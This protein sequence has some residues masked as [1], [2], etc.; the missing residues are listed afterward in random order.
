MRPLLEEELLQSCET[1]IKC[2]DDDQLVVR[3]DKVFRFDHVFSPDASQVSNRLHQLL[4]HCYLYSHTT[5]A[6]D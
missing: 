5:C 4:T 2:V 6:T 1:T 3:G